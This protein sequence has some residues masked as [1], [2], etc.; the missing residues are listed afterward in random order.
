VEE[1]QGFFLVSRCNTAI[2]L[3][4]RTETFS[5]HHYGVNATI[6]SM[7]LFVDGQPAISNVEA[8]QYPPCSLP[9][10]LQFLFMTGVSLTLL[11][12]PRMPMHYSRV[13]LITASTIY[14][15]LPVGLSIAMRR[16][17]MMLLLP[18]IKRPRIRHARCHMFRLCIYVLWQ[19]FA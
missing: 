14:A 16:A 15:V 7:I 9:Y 4:Q 5:F 17:A 11:F 13:L 6:F 1:V 18:T 3:L 19:V 10:C 8:C 2:F 12:F